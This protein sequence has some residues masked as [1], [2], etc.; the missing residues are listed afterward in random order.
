MRLQR[1]EGKQLVT[2]YQRPH[3]DLCSLQIQQLLFSL[4]EQYTLRSIDFQIESP[5]ITTSNL[6]NPT[7][8][9]MTNTLWSFG[10]SECKRV[11]DGSRFLELFCKGKNHVIAELRYTDLIDL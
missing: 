4:N 5:T 9:R 2:H 3:L 11:K 6:V 7:P 10:H 1:L 8:L